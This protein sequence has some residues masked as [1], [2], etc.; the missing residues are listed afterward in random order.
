MLDWMN[1][2]LESSLTLNVK[3]EIWHRLYFSYLAQS[4]WMLVFLSIFDWRKAKRKRNTVSV[5]AAAA[6]HWYFTCQ[7]EHFP[8]GPNSPPSTV[9]QRLAPHFSVRDDAFEKMPEKAT[10]YPPLIFNLYREVA[11]KSLQFVFIDGIS[12]RC[13]LSSPPCSATHTADWINQH[14]NNL[15]YIFFW[16]C[17]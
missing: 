17:R 16:G 12:S 8:P 6:I 10:R 3:I 2:R 11:L 5:S 9:A 14:R 13:L 7:R 1:D 15:R 4:C